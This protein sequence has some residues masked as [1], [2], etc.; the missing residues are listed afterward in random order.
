MSMKEIEIDEKVMERYDL[1]S[2]SRTLYSNYQTFMQDINIWIN[3]KRILPKEIFEQIGYL[4]ATTVGHKIVNDFVMKFY[5][6]EQMLKYALAKRY[7]Q[8]ENE[9]SAFE[10]R[11]NDSRLDVGR[12]NG[13]SYAY[14]IKTEFDSLDKLRKQ[15]ED[16]ST[17]FEYVYVLV[18]EIHLEK[19]LQLAPDHCGI[20]SYKEE[21]GEVK[22]SFRKKVNRSEK[23]SK[24]SML[25]NLNLKELTKILKELGYN[26]AAKEPREIKENLLLDFNDQKI[27]ALF[28]R[29]L[30][31]RY[32]NQWRNLQ[33]NFEDIYPIDMQAVFKS[34]ASPKQIYY[35]N[36]FSV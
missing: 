5:P 24:E 4:E 33:E 9:V 3:L 7:I 23:L 16:Y 1:T 10:I 12:I 6:G 34:S 8:K 14:E 31:E 21:K 32:N 35:K 26:Q 29:A 25:N 18:H 20:I 27:N 36:S 11:V 19:T 15:I 17:V 13:N 30:K 28:K 22:L 2:I